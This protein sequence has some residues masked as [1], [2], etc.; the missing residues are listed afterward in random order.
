MTNYNWI[1]ARSM[2]QT[3]LKRKEPQVDR[4]VSKI[5]GQK[6]LANDQRLLKLVVGFKR[7]KDPDDL[8]PDNLMRNPKFLTEL[9]KTFNG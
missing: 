4:E 1:S 9:K 7:S 6:I 5:V 2:G 3:N 8:K